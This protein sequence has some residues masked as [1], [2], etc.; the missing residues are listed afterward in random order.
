M[1]NSRSQAQRLYKSSSKYVYLKRDVKKAKKYWG[2]A[3]DKGDW[4]AK[5]G[6]QKI[7]EG[8]DE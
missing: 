4:I 7:Y 5:E 1:F 3:A 2:M 8:D 6:L